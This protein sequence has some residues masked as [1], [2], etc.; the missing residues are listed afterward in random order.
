M[1]RIVL[2]TNCLVQ[3][4]SSRSKYHKIWTDF[5]DGKYLLC[6]SNSILDEYEEI[7]ERVSSAFVAKS[8]LKAICE[9]P[10]TIFKEANYRF[11][12][13]QADVDDNKFVDCAIVSNAKYIVSDDTHFS[14]LENISFPCV[15]VIGIDDFLVH[16]MRIMDVS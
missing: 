5:L 6:V 16:L 8:I 13:I 10:Y 12:L 2:D 9:S 7:L 15:S 11:E 14:V 3:S 4:I 1:E